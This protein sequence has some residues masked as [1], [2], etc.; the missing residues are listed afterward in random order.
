MITR[1]LVEA[2]ERASGYRLACR[3]RI[4][5]NASVT[6]APVVVSL[7]QDLPHATTISAGVPLGLAI[8]LA[9][10]PWP[11]SSPR[12]MPGGFALARPL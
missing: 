4:T 8:D 10:P 12:W 5:G 7:Q 1:S 9:A 2:A 11:P 3:A 6:L